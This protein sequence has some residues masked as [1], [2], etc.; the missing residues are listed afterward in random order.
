LRRIILL[1][2]LCIFTCARAAENVE[3]RVEGL[4][5]PLEE[6]VRAFLSI[7]SLGEEPAEGEDPVPFSD[8]EIRRLH[9]Q[10]PGEVRQALQPFGFYSPTVESSL[11]RED[12]GWVATYDVDAGA[13]TR[14]EHAEIAVEGEAADLPEVKALLADIGIAEGDVLSHPAYES[15]KN[16]LLE[17]VYSA[18][19]LDAKYRRSEMLVHPERQRAGIYLLLESGSRYFFGD[20]EIEQD[21]LDP[22]FV[23]R[24]NDIERG[25][26]FD[27]ER[28]IDLQL[29]LSG[30]DYFSTVDVRVHRERT[31]DFH[32]PVTVTALP[33]DPQSYS[34]GLGYG[35]DTGPRLTIGTEF[36]RINRRG[37][38][39]TADIQLSAVRN[40]FIVQYHV[41]IENVTTDRLTYFTSL[42][43]VEI[44]DADS[45]VF[46]V[47]ASREDSW[48]GLRRRFYLRF[49]RENF[50]FGEQPGGDATLLYPGINLTY[51]RANDT[52]FPRR[53]V[54]AS[55]DLHGA[56]G[57]FLSETSFLQATLGLRTVF[58]LG[59]RGRLLLRGDAGVTAAANFADLPP[60]QRFFTGGD[61]TVRGYGFEELSPED[62]FGNDVGGQYLLVGSVEA[63]YLVWGNF[64]VAAF[65]DTGNAMNDVSGDLA[66]GVGLGLRYRSPVGMIRIDFAHPLD[67]PE[68]NFRLHISLGPDL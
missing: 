9:R 59:A 35:T 49:D 12:G 42:Q 27:T 26:P 1:T 60:S 2:S 44:G 43:R 16:G 7:A 24:F 34:V 30:S 51:Q 58:P 20:V 53:G 65:V 41:P 31:A 13:P 8:N 56:P 40:S 67:D 6:N 55:L 66:T 48:H 62:S 47:G 22:A 10:A 25:E 14:V 39:L 4:E 57:S 29:G 61:R 36:R 45:D 15:A 52:L 18:G 38:Q 19:Y 46:S 54:S 23:R 50:T 68:Q 32:V 21:V 28:L 63:D 37:H 5:E 17:A 64:G 11:V 33:R 3:V